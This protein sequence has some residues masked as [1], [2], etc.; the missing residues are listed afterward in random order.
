MRFR[1][2]HV[3]CGCFPIL[4]GVMVICL[5]YLVSSVAVIAVASSD[6]P[7]KIAGVK[8]IPDIQLVSAAWSW[9]GIPI[10]IGAAM[11]A[12]YR[13]E[14]HIRLFFW[15]LVVTNVW[16]SIVG[17]YF[18]TMGTFC[19]AMMPQDVQRIGASFVCGFTDTAVFLWVLMLATFNV[20]FMYVIWSAAEDIKELAHPQ[21]MQ[22]ADALRSVPIPAPPMHGP[23]PIGDLPGLAHGLKEKKK[24]QSGPDPRLFL[25]PGPEAYAHID[26]WGSEAQRLMPYGTV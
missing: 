12:L 11:G 23:V 5:M 21:L 19:E 20:Y 1:P 18:L 17:T 15:Y 8:I 26:Q 13:V 16:G 2:T 14:K 7:L 25:I 6:V 22:Y 4:V 9:I 10:A 24:K 3:F